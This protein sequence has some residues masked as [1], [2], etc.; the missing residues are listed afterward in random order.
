MPR[1]TSTGDSKRLPRCVMTDGTAIDIDGWTC[2][3]PLRDHDRVVLGHGG[4][5]TLSAEL[6]E[7]LIVPAFGAAARNARPT[8]A[9]VLTLDGGVRLALTTDTFVVRPLVFPGGNIGD[10]AINGTVNDLAMQGAR[11]LWMS[12][13]FVLEEGLELAML[14][15]IAATMGRAASDGRS[16]ARD[17]RHEGRRG[18]PRRR[19]VH[20]HRGGRTG[21]GR[22]R[23][24]PGPRRARG[25][26]HRQRADRDAR[27]RGAQRAR[28]PGVR[29]RAGLGHRA[30]RGPRAG[31]PRR[32]AG[33]RRTARAA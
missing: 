5:G 9:A 31:A 2:P 26:R 15:H 18:G 12:T 28:R 10:L 20:Q 30:A 17:G 16:R 27:R 21:R 7:H 25:C 19:A 22:R 1:T 13:A 3:A 8:D 23:R 11:P 32:T 14:E 33:A 4:G 6:I 24:S 29:H